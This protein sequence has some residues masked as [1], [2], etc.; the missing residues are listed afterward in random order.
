MANRHQRRANQRQQ[1]QSRPELEVVTNVAPLFDDEPVA[2]TAIP[3]AA[4]QAHKPG[5]FIRLLA[6]V[7]LS[8]WILNRVKH[9]DVERLL[10]TFAAEA[11][12]PDIADELTRRQALRGQ[13]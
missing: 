2:H 5:I 7:I 10:I 6:K 13:R 9:S 3:S 4:P 11:G 1:R 12:K 8:R